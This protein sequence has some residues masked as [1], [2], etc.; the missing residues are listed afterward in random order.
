MFLIHIHLHN[1]HSPLLCFERL[2][3]SYIAIKKINTILKRTS[4][5]GFTNAHTAKIKF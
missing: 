5:F 1:S 3:G 2:L 4:N